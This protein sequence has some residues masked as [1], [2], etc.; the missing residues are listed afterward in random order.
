MPT[1]GHF[2]V[3]R[4][5]WWQDVSQ[6]NAARDRQECL[7]TGKHQAGLRLP[8]FSSQLGHRQAGHLCVSHLPLSA[9]GNTS[10]ILLKC[11]GAQG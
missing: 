8:A 10:I 9:E 4:H 11:V 6:A 3:H 2:H 7:P 1:Q 5:N